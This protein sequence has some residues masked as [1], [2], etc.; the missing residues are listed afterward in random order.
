MLDVMLPCG[1]NALK[2]A[3]L[4]HNGSRRTSYFS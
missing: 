3:H 2:N 4:P 1:V